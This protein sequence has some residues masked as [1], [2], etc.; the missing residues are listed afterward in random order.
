MSKLSEAPKCPVHKM[1]MLIM[2]GMG[3]DYDRFVCGIRGCDEEIEMDETTCPED[4]K[5][6]K[7]DKK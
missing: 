3:W 6:I 2:Y 1:P 7:D 5:E 4:F